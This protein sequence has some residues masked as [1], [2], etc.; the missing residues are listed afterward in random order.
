[1]RTRAL[2]ALL[3]PLAAANAFLMPFSGPKGAWVQCGRSIHWM[4]FLIDHAFIKRRR[5]RHAACYSYTAP[6]ITTSSRGARQQQACRGRDGAGSAVRDSSD[7]RSMSIDQITDACW[8]KLNPFVLIIHGDT[9]GDG[10][11]ISVLGL[12]TPHYGVNM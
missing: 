2:L 11:G 7:G 1:M 3:G 4:H 10:D 6:I 9:P 12:T 5:R 8:D